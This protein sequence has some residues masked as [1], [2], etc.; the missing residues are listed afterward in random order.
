MIHHSLKWGPPPHIVRPA[1]R[2]IEGTDAGRWA[3]LGG[4]LAGAAG[5]VVAAFAARAG[6]RVFLRAVRI[7]RGFGW[8]CYAAATLQ[9]LRRCPDCRRL[10]RRDC[11]VCR[12]CGWRRGQ[13]GPA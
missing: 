4:V 6:F 7:G 9:L 8:F 2:S 10:I 13:A 11:R 1:V 12:H 3:A 5:A